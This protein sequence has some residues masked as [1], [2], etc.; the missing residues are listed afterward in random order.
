MARK[1][2]IEMYSTHNEGKIVFSKRFIRTLK[3]KVYKYMTS[4]SKNVFID[5]LEDIVNK[6]DNTYHSTTN[7]KRMKPG[8]VKSNT[9]IDPS[10]EINEKDPIFKI[11]DIVRIS[12]YKSIFAK[13]Y[14]PS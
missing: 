4:V 10:Q 8:D 3:L 13:G 14:I 12:K 5:K 7:L 9:Y 1:N 2:D 6:C 11:G